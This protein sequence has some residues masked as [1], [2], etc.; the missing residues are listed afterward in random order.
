V[1]LLPDSV[2]L[3]NESAQLLVQILRLFQSE[4]M[5]VIVPGNRVDAVEAQSLMSVRQDQV[6]DDPGGPHLDGGEGHAHLSRTLRKCFKGLV[7]RH[8]M[9]V[10]GNL[11]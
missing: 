2:C 1:L 11:L 9:F 3:F 5:Y 6:T 10:T 7:S 8:T 4:V